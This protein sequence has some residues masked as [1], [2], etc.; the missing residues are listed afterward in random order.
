MPG[1]SAENSGIYLFE[2]DVQASWPEEVG[3]NQSVVVDDA[4]PESWK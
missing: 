1:G 3:A 4:L 2:A